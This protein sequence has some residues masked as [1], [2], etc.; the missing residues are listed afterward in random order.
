MSY[1]IAVRTLCQHSNANDTANIAAGRV[2]RSLQLLSQLFEAV[3]IHR[4]ALRVHRPVSLADSVESEP[5]PAY[6]IALGFAC[7]GLVD[8]F[9]INPDRVDRPVISE[10]LDL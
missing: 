4:S 9:D 8:D 10:A 5:H 3:G 7:V 6:L 2:E 1:G